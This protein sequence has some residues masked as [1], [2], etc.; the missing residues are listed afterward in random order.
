M[1]VF[2]L[3]LA[4]Q[5]LGRRNRHSSCGALTSCELSQKDSGFGANSKLSRKFPFFRFF[6]ALLKVFI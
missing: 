3:F 6:Y 1:E 2:Y 5:K 4:A